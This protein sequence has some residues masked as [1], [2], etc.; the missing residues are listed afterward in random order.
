MLSVQTVLSVDCISVASRQR[1]EGMVTLLRLLRSPGEDEASEAAMLYFLYNNGK[2]GR[3]RHACVMIQ[4]ALPDES[5]IAQEIGSRCCFLRYDLTYVDV[6]RSSPR[7]IVLSER[8]SSQCGSRDM[9]APP[10][11]PLKE[12]QRDHNHAIMR[13]PQSLETYTEYKVAKP[14]R[15]FTRRQVKQLMAAKWQH[16]QQ[17]VDEGPKADFSGGTV[18]NNNC[19][20]FARTLWKMLALGEE[21]EDVPC[22]ASSD[23]SP[24]G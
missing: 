7:S 21:L 18:A 20:T 10:K 14:C 16:R 5:K 3:I 23:L 17:Y 1:R 8:W 11:Q 15:P 24:R 19:V 13:G 4:Y 22:S 9:L 12:Q 6:E 2:N